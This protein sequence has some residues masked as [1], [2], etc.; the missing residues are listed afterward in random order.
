MDTMSQFFDDFGFNL[1]GK[2]KDGKEYYYGGYGRDQYSCA[3]THAELPSSI[4]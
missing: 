2:S 3:C 4:R 1:V